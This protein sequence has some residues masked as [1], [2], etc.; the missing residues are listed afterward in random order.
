MDH[1]IRSEAANYKLLCEEVRERFSDIDDDTLADTVEGLSDLPD[2]L[3]GLVRSALEDHVLAMALRERIREMRARL[4]R[5]D[6]S[7]EKKRAIVKDAMDRA[8]LKKLIQPD[9]TASVAAGAPSLVVTDQ[10]SISD[11]FWIPQPDKLDRQ[12]LLSHLKAGNEIRGAS[13][14]VGKST[15]T[16]RTK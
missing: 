2:L 14:G 3:S 4:D 16:V 10:M 13:L 7:V 15:L 12:F 5:L 1:E 8:N 11:E 6:S 9:F